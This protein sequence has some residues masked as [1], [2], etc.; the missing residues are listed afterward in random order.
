MMHRIILDV[1]EKTGPQR[2]FHV[3]R[4]A[5]A[6]Y[7]LDASLFSLHG[8]LL[9]ADYPAAQQLAQRLNEARD[10]RRYPEL[11]VRAGELYAA[12]LLDE[13]FHYLLATYRRQVNP[14]LPAELLETLEHAVGKEKLEQTLTRFATDF[15]ATPVYRGEMSVGEYLAGSEEG[16]SHRYIALEE[17][18]LLH[19]SN[20]NPGYS[21]LLELLDDSELEKYTAYLKLMAAFERLL[22]GSPSFQGQPGSL[23]SLLRAPSRHSP[24]SLSGQL[25]YVRAHWQGLLGERFSGLLEQMLRVLDVLAE[26]EKG[27][28]WGGPG[29]GVVLDAAALRGEGVARAPLEYE[30]FSADSSWMPR[31]VMIAKSTFVWLDQLA[32]EYGREVHRLDQ[33][34]DEELD[35]LASSGF[36]ALWLIGLW[37]RSEASRRIKHLRGNPDAV[38][39]A[40]A[41]YDYVIARDL[42]GEEAYRN[43]HDRAHQRGIRLASDMVPNHVGIDGRW[44]IEHPDWFLQ[45]DHSP[46]PSYSFNGPDLSQDERVGIFIEDHYYDGTDAAVV[47]KRVDRWTGSERYIYHGNDGTLIPWNDTAQLDYLKAE[48]REAVIQTILHVARQF[49]I[50]RFDAAMTLAKQHIQRLWFPEPGTGGAIPSRAQFSLSK[51]EFDR[52]MPEE[53]WREVVDRVAAE[54]P[55]T[56]LLAEAFWMLEGYFVRTLGMHRVYN[57]AFMNMLGREAN[58]EYRQSVKN[59]LEFD[60]E[61]L[62]RY[63]NFMNNPD[64]ETALA[65]F[66]K[67]DKYFGVCTLLV[68]MPGLPMF[69][70]GQIEGYTEKYGMEY[71]HPKYDEKPDTWLVE[72]HQREIFPLLHRRWQF[73]EVENFLLFDVYTPEGVN[74]D[75]FAYSNEV[76]GAA[77]L[78]LYNNKFAE[79]RG[80]IKTS[81]PYSRKTG[82]GD[83]RERVQRS[84]AEGLGLRGGENLF[85]VFRE[86]IGGL[87]YLRRTDELMEKGFY[88][89]L[90]AFKYQVFLDFRQLEDYD[91]WLARLSGELGGRG[92]PNVAE[93][94]EELRLRPLHE[95]F[96]ALL[97]PEALRPLAAGKLSAEA[98]GRLEDA[99]AEFLKAAGEYGLTAPVKPLQQAF[100]ETLKAWPPKVSREVLEPYLDTSLRDSVLLLSWAALRPLEN[101][102]AR[103]KDWRLSLADE[104]GERLTQLLEVLLHYPRWFE[105]ELSELLE[106]LLADAGVLQLLRVNEHAGVRWFNR[107]AYRELLGALLQAGLLTSQDDEAAR[108]LVVTRALE[109]QTAEMRSEYR[110]EALRAEPPQVTQKTASEGKGRKARETKKPGKG[111]G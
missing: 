40:Y 84:L 99:Y 4:K 52:L 6:R 20:E 30:R 82:Q 2:E 8:H 18:L 44:V 77:S 12:G 1:G 57:S 79:A 3:T 33:I 74:E 5:R 39:S 36:T 56:L 86:H 71:R 101:V 83:E 11:A 53:F 38:A 62:K 61:I 10:A 80:W 24:T 31:V 49:P 48:V 21:K 60:P 50:I 34:P 98:R 88:L 85:T 76:G 92:V 17:M 97:E 72:R 73:A 68:T 9:V 107:E 22:D 81:L 42:G 32:R 89:E 27:G 69:G 67:D 100:A 23:L 14:G 28:L 111:K 64:E 37:E 110:L 46:Y 54:V 26:E 19:L 75:V 13:I 108:E 78:V 43:L 29:P 16:V 41:L 25:Q 35:R 63:V 93:A 15:P 105:L 90:G 104:E 7:A 51:E 102:E 45:L 70:H 55:D 47:F 59:V 58:Q 65:Q 91:G 94:V 66:G 96:T 95:A 103:L 109:L 106:R 87:E